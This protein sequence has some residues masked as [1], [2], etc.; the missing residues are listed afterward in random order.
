MTR[1]TLATAKQEALDRK[2]TADGRWTS[3]HER[4]ISGEKIDHQT[5]AWAMQES[6][7][8]DQLCIN[9]KIRL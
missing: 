5:I 7:N 3:I 4:L 2:K 9:L 8:A 6:N 1:S